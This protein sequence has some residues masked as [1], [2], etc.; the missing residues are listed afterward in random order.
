MVG[1]CVLVTVLLECGSVSGSGVLSKSERLAT[2]AHFVETDLTRGFESFIGLETL[3]EVHPVLRCVAEFLLY[4]V[5]A[6]AI[7]Y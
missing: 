1:R 7:G 3:L 2:S 4:T 5:N 6:W